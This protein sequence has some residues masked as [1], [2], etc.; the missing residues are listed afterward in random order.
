VEI[1]LCNGHSFFSLSGF[2][3]DAP[4]RVLVELL[5]RAGLTGSE[6]KSVSYMGLSDLF[7][8]FRQG[9]RTMEQGR[10][11]NSVSASCPLALRGRR[12]QI[13]HRVSRSIR[14]RPAP[15][16]AMQSERGARRMPRRSVQQVAGAE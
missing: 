14:A 6:A 15:K 12:T 11:G 8:V 4:L 2:N 13:I 16:A 7:I 9:A 1:G 5:P 3:M 10:S